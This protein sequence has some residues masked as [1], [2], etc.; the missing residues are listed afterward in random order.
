MPLAL[1]SPLT[2][3]QKNHYLNDL[4]FWKLYC[5]VKPKSWSERCLHEVTHIFKAPLNCSSEEFRFCPLHFLQCFWNYWLCESPVSNV[6]VSLPLCCWYAHSRSVPTSSPVAWWRS[7]GNK[8]DSVS[9]WIKGTWN[10]ISSVENADVCKRRCLL[11][12]V[13]GSAASVA[14]RVSVAFRWELQ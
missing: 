9:Q 12:A 5:Y 4:D 3:A 7:K 13:C 1:T 14:P 11:F 8:H 10:E 6:G 2:Q